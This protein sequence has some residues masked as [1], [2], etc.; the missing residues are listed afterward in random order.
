[1]VLGV[2]GFSAAELREMMI[3]N[4]AALESAATSSEKTPAVEEDPKDDWF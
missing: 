4:F 3:A 2:G 1:M